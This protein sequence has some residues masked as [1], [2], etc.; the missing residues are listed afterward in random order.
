MK[1]SMAKF[2]ETAMLALGW[3]VE[4]YITQARGFEGDTR[5]RAITP[6]GERFGGF[7]APDEEGAWE[8]RVPAF[9]LDEQEALLDSVFETHCVEKM[10]PHRWLKDQRMLWEVRGWVPDW[11]CYE[12]SSTS[13]AVA[14]LNAVRMAKGLEAVEVED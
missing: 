7:G 9:G 11:A 3:R 2:K 5:W 8:C 12:Q 4:P 10:L 13:R 1:L 6:T 14:V